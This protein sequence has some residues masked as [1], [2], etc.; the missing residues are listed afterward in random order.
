[1][2]KVIIATIMILMIIMI[3]IK[4]IYVN[5]VLNLFKLTIKT[6]KFNQLRLF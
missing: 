2:S 5:S 1:M 4:I 6:P 3:I